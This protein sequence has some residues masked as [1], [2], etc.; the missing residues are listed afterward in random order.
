MPPRRKTQINF[1]DQRDEAC[2]ITV[3][4]EGNRLIEIHEL[5]LNK[6]HPLSP[7][8][9]EHG[10]K[11]IVIGHPGF[12]KSRIVEHLMLYKSWICP[13]AQAYSGTETENHFY[14]NR[15]TPISVFNDLDLKQMEEF[16]KRQGLAR[17]YLPNP[18]AF[19]VLDD[20]TD[21][22]T[23]LKKPPFPAY[24]RKGRWW[25]MLHVEAVQYPMD[26]PP[27]QRSC[28][29]YVFILANGIMNE[30]EKLYENFAS[31]AIPT[32]QDFCDI[33]DQCTENFSALVIDN[34]ST[35]PLIKDRVFY[36]KADLERVPPG[37]R[38]GCPEAWAFNNG[39]MD[40]NY[41]DSYL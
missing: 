8:D 11:C 16:V 17:Q 23:K 29:D 27:G 33:L 1:D 30:R 22:P 9:L 3:D 21:D 41:V 20:C 26:I 10:A 25:A 13:V 32:F 34:T 14:K 5:D 6:I 15:M 18:W 31:G 24:F 28:V 19:Q 12:G 36:F 35:S 38:M 37:F 7:D 40:P 2:G 39:R 4:E